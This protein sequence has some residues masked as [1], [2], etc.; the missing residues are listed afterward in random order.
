M[1]VVGPAAGDGHRPTQVAEG[2][3]PAEQGDDADPAGQ[4]LADQLAAE[5]RGGGGRHQLVAPHH[6]RGGEGLHPLPAE[7]VLPRELL[8]R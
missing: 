6:L 8:P 2:V 7:L 1:L 4:Q 5:G 3:G